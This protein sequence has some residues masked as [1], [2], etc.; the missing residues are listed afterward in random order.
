[1]EDQALAIQESCNPELEPCFEEQLLAEGSVVD[2]LKVPLLMLWLL[3]MP[4]ISMGLS[5]YETTEPAE[6]YMYVL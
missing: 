5:G 3:L 6:I 1:M 2:F 4:M